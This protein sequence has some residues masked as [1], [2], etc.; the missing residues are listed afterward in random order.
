MRIFADRLAEQ[1][2]KQLHPIYL[3]FGNEPLLLQESREAI[4]QTAFAHGFEERHRFA[5]SSNLDWN[6]VYDCCQAMSLFS[7]KQVIELE[8][9]ETGVNAA[10]AKELLAVAE[11]IHPDVLLVIIGS[12]LTKAQESA[13]WFKALSSQ[14]CWVNCLTPDIQRLPQFVQQRCRKMGLQPDQEAVQ[15]LAQW[16]EGNLFAL[17]QSLE[18]LV[19]LYPDGQLNLVRLEHA[20]SRHNHFTAFH[21][22]DALLAGK[23][24]RSQRILR[25]LEAEGIES[26]ILIRTL[27][28]ELTQLFAMASLLNSQT[29][30]QVFEQYRIWQS[31][32]PLYSAALQRLNPSLLAKQLQL[33]AQAEITAK[34]QYEIS[35]WPLL[36]Q[37][38]CQIC[39]PQVRI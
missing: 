30:A 36:H 1:L 38:S 5:V 9:P 12:K 20:L 25:Q 8:L 29:L 17:S 4:Q 39:L 14:G 13:K 7:A 31:K 21:W 32:R 22:V 34:T 15:M 37:L 27:Q 11:L 10:I 24:K 33:L 23:A 6:Q 3:I 16:H 18:K 35:C 26:V 19:L 2:V 28:K